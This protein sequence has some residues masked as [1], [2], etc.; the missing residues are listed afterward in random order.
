MGQEPVAEPTPGADADADPDEEPVDYAARFGQNV[1]RSVAATLVRIHRDPSPVLNE[2]NRSR[3]LNV[4]S[5]SLKLPAAWP[6]TRDLLMALA[7]KLEQAGHWGEWLPYLIK[8]LTLSEAVDDLWASAELRLHLGHLHRLQSRWT[9]A[10]ALLTA[11]ARGFAALGERRSQARALNQLAYVAWQQHRPR[12]VETLAH[13]AQALL[14][15]TDIEYA[16]SLSALGLAAIEQHQWQAAEAYH[17]AALQIRA[18]H[19]DRR[20]MAWS[21]QNVGYALRGQGHYEAASACYEEAIATLRDL[22]DVA[23]CAIAQMNLGIVYSLRGEPAKALEVYAMAES[24]FRRI[25][26]EGNLAQILVNQGIDYMALGNWQ[27]AG[28]VFM[29]SAHLF[30]R[31]ANLSGYLNAL[32]GLGI[33]YLE[34][35]LYEKALAIF[36]S[37]AVQLPK[38][39]GTQY[40]RNLTK[41]IHSQLDRAKAGDSGASA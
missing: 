35:N 23:H 6:A 22:N 25:G 16:M 37:V 34:Q 21:L 5:Y 13:Q 29:T 17:R 41:V 8:G 1:M 10:R 32:D 36:E 2:E 39:E 7:P 27:R 33:S 18:A 26:D 28:S 19:G 11:S 12:E 31:L 3:A 14:D 9:Q 38:I 15:E 20:Q 30:Q 24:T 4:L 40:H